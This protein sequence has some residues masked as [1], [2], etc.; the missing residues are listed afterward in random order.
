MCKPEQRY[1]DYQVLY[2][3]VTKTFFLEPVLTGTQDLKQQTCGQTSSA[4]MRCN[5]QNWLAALDAQL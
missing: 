1:V 2:D 4:K 5:K 3:E